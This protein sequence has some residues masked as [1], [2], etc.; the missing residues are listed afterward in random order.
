MPSNYRPGRLTM[1]H[2][3]NEF[4]VID[5]NNNIIGRIKRKQIEQDAITQLTTWQ[6]EKDEFCPGPIASPDP[7]SDIGPLR[8]RPTKKELSKLVDKLRSKFPEEDE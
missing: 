8:K 2:M 7:F 1:I 6:P 4:V 3:G 5:E